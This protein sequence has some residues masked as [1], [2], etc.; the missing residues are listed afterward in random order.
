MSKKLSFLG[1][2]LPCLLFGCG[3]KRNQSLVD[4]VQD[5]GQQQ[6]SEENPA[7][8]TARAGSRTEE[9]PGTARTL[10]LPSSASGVELSGLDS[11][12]NPLAPVQVQGAV[13]TVTDGIPL[14]KKQIPNLILNWVPGLIAAQLA[15]PNIGPEVQAEGALQRVVLGRLALQRNQSGKTFNFSFGTEAIGTA[16]PFIRRQTVTVGNQGCGG[17]VTQSEGASD[18]VFPVYPEFIETDQNN[19]YFNVYAKLDQEELSLLR[20]QE[21]TTQTVEVTDCQSYC[22]R[23]RTNQAFSMPT[24]TGEVQ[25]AV[26]TEYSCL[27][28]SNCR[29]RPSLLVPSVWETRPVSSPFFTCIQ[30]ST[31]HVNPHTLSETESVTQIELSPTVGEAKVRVLPADVN[32]NDASVGVMGSLMQFPVTQVPPVAE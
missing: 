24:F 20:P 8:F 31:E 14:W 25:I 4:V 11:K 22:S 27:P 7:K 12:G 17:S 18:E 13:G 2:L 26:G 32:G 21:R 29:I 6:V 30:N 23:V 5:Q 15:P 3:S 19:A 10:I 28:D 1:L 9:L 16:R